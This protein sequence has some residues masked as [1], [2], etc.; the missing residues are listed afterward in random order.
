MS[1]FTRAILV[2]AHLTLLQKNIRRQDLPSKRLNPGN[3][4]D[5]HAFERS[6]A[7]SYRN[8]GQEVKPITPLKCSL[9]YTCYLSTS[10]VQALATTP[11]VTKRRHIRP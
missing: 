1:L 9:L 3:K 10:A 8:D 6:E 5:V 11:C 4:V 7:S 2:V